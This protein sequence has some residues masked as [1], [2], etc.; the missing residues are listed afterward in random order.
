MNRRAVVSSYNWGRGGLSRFCAGMNLPPLVSKRTYNDHLKQILKA[1]EENAEELMQ[2]AAK[3]LIDLVETKSPDCIETVVEERVANVAVTV[4]GTWQKRGH[5]SKIG[6]VFVISVWT[7][8]ILDYEV[9]SLHCSECKAHEHLDNECDPYK[10]WK[11]SHSSSCQV[12]HVGSSEEMEAE[13]AISI[14]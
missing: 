6:V 2:E 12:N 8:L 7:G 9:K 1:A 11:E 4:D 5:S 10:Q 13:G 14:F 3:Q